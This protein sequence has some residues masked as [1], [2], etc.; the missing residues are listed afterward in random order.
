MN[1]FQKLF[2]EDSNNIPSHHYDRIE[3][4]VWG[5]LGFFRLLGDVAEIYMTKMVGVM[6]MA[7]GAEQ[8]EVAMIAPK[9]HR[10]APDALDRQ[11]PEP[12]KQ[13]P[14]NPETPK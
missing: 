7:T 5:N 11:A 14:G 3:E 10:S 4:A 13:A 1:N 8:P 6:I 9:P 12:G 2:E